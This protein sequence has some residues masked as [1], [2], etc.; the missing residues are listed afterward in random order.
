MRLTLHLRVRAN[1]IMR[2]SVGV[3][4][5]AVR[6]RDAKPKGIG[7]SFSALSRGTSSISSYLVSF[8]FISLVFLT[9]LILPGGFTSGSCARCTWLEGRSVIPYFRYFLASSWSMMVFEAMETT[10]LIWS[11]FVKTVFWFR[12]SCWGSLGSDWIYWT[13]MNSSSTG[14]WYLVGLQLLAG[15]LPML[16]DIINNFD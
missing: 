5:G 12:V 9:P 3:I 15:V 16:T 7:F 6:P 2:D 8:S 14:A 13:S 1:S 11:L 4:N 10:F